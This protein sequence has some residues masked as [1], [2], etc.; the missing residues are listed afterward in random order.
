[1]VINDNIIKGIC[2][3]AVANLRNFKQNQS[4]II[5]GESGSGKTESTKY[6]LQYL[7]AVSSDGH[8]RGQWIEELILE[9]NTILESFGNAKTSRN[10][11]SSRF[12]KFI[13][14][15][16]NQSCEIVGSTI[17]SYLLEKSRVVTAAKNERCYHCFYELIF[18]STDLEKEKYLLLPEAS[19]YRYLKKSGCLEIE[20]VSDKKHFGQLKVAFAIH[21]LTSS[22]IDSIFKI[23]SAILHLGNVKFEI[24]K[25]CA[26]I[27]PGTS[28][29]DHVDCV[30]TLL[31]CN[32]AALIDSL[33]F[34]TILVRGE[35]MKM[36]L[37]ESQA[38]DNID[39]VS[40]ILYER[41]FNFLVDLMNKNTENSQ[42][43]SF[44]GV[45]DIFG[46]ELFETNSFEQFCI[47]FTNEKLQQLFNTYIFKLELTEV[48]CV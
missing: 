19:M 36:P 48:L 30:S 42:A 28:G 1:L 16:F 7:T 34:K 20:G 26:T 8:Q 39:S 40:K 21:K 31:E 17:Q 2:E 9:S 15:L 12:G 11:N 4:I 45:L 38:I 32:T 25:E 44:I 14:V 6:L 23:L 13:Q 10:N 27:Q 47:N 5:S 33:T 41:V 3:A 18:G 37:T 35:T 29:S 22:E 43:Q 24:V 46:F